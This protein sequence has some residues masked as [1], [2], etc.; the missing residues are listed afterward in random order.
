MVYGLQ[1]I[2]L[3]LQQRDYSIYMGKFFC[4]SIIL[5]SFIGVNAQDTAKAKLKVFVDCRE[6]CDVTFLKT[7]ITIVDFVIDRTAADA[8]VLITSQPVGSGGKEYQLNFYGQN[9][10]KNYIDT[11]RFITKP[12]AADA[13]IRQNLLQYLM[14]G[15]APLIAKTAFASNV[16]I[17]M[18]GKDSAGV[19]ADTAKTKDKWNYWVYTVGVKGELRA[20]QV[21]KTNIFSSDFSANRATDKIKT[22]FYGYGSIN[23]T[24]YNYTNGDT[25]TTYLVKNREFGFYHHMVKS[26]G[27]H[28]SV[29]YQTNFSNNTFTNIKRRLYFKPAVEYNI[30]N[31]KDVNNSLLVIRYGVDIT[32]NLYYDTTIFDKKSETLYGNKIS[33]TLTFNKKWGTINTGIQ[34][35]NFFKDP[36]L[37]SMGMSVN[38]DVKI[39]GAFSFFVNI[40]A[41]IAHD[42]INL[43]KSGASEQEV[44]TRKRQIA[45]NFNYNT[46]FGINY[47]FGSI[48]NNFVNPRFEGYG[49][50]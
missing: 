24:T 21:Y 49:G 2:T 39:S 42:Q 19:V 34:Y 3:P 29:G 37:N 23:N 16:T 28:W 26:L 38:A 5:L 17:S 6:G 40:N 46:S 45:S 50:F 10:Y 11:L 1:H 48:L 8:H 30:Y 18:K 4:L 22:S 44:L 32:N 31:F 43:V 25:T 15:F 20:D 12:N 14:L 27:P 9:D 13:E 36:K 41:S 35:R 33:A 47:R 7:E